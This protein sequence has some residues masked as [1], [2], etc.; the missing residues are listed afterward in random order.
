MNWTTKFNH[1][2]DTMTHEFSSVATLVTN[3]KTGEV[4]LMSLG[5]KI[6]TYDLNHFTVEDYAKM[7]S[8]ISADAEKL[9]ELQEVEG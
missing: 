4:Y 3:F 5:M 1:K 2:D 9:Q 7:L 8:R 6:A